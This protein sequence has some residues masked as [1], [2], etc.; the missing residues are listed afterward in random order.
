M[1]ARSLRRPRIRARAL[2]SSSPRRIFTMEQMRAKLVALA[3][4]KNKNVY[5]VETLGG[6]E[7][8]PRVLYRISP[9]GKR[10]LVRGAA[11]DDLDQRALR[12]D[13]IAAGGSPGSRSRSPLCPRL[14]SCR[15]SCSM[16]SPSS[17]PTRSSRS[18]RTIRLRRS[19]QIRALAYHSRAIFC[20]V[21]VR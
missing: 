2:S 11:F 14:P 18:F 9:D 8:M 17:A 16:T 10:T 13:I 20:R 19:Q 4:E 1:A 15:R 3:K 5:E 6:G 21:H 7:L 12:A